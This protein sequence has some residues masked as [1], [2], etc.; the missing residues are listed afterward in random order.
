MQSLKKTIGK[1]LR[2]RRTELR[3][4]LETL[5]KHSGVTVSVLSNIENGKANPT[6]DTLEKIL[7]ILG[8]TLQTAIIER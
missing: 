2:A 8:I 6:L 3:L 5:N 7:V 1:S 4:D